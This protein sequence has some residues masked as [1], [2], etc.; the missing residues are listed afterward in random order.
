MSSE[1]VEGNKENSG[2]GGGDDNKN[3]LAAAKSPHMASL[4]EHLEKGSEIK[5]TM[6]IDDDDENLKAK[7]RRHKN[8]LVQSLSIIGGYGLIFT[9]LS[10]RTAKR[11]LFQYFLGC[12]SVFV[13][14]LIVSILVT[15]MLCPFDC[16]P[17]SPCH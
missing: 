11:G 1:E 16:T 2:S 10:Y 13:V 3:I 4:D 9:T 15:G 14:V 17:H 6:L 7:R 8:P 5:K 12:G